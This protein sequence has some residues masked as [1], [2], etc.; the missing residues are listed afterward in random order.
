M[1]G[2]PT[3][4]TRSTRHLP[5]ALLLLTTLSLP[6]TSHGQ[7]DDEALKMAA[8]ESLIMAPEERA[9]PI[10]RR[11][12]EGDDSVTLKSR[13]LFVLSQMDA[14]EAQALLL[15]AARSDE[16]RLAAEAVRMIGINGDATAMASLGELYSGGSPDLRKAVLE[17]YLIADDATAVYDI[18][19]NAQSE[20]EFARAVDTL[21][22]MGAIEE[23]RALRDVTGYSERLIQALSIVSDLETL[24][25]LAR[26]DSDPRRQAQ[27]IKAIGIVGGDDANALLVDIY[28]GTDN[29]NVRQAALHG[30]MVAGDDQRILELYRETTDPKAK[31]MMLRMLTSMDSDAAW[32]AIDSV[33]GG[34]G[35]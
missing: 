9:L 21:G 22:A 32:D 15:D 16:P 13:A 18:A 5:L 28:R 8:L 2:H 31:Q 24:T 20:T 23:L 34:D 4:T 7:S 1:N 26:D 17:A 25:E 33:L 19:A 30:L 35:E 10:V 29:A 6:L 12:L 11:V 14:P 27:A 3:M